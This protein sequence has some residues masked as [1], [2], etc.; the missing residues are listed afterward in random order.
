MYLSNRYYIDFGFY[1]YDTAKMI[2]SYI[3]EDKE[4][5]ST[6]KIGVIGV[7]ISNFD[8][9]KQLKEIGRL[10]EPAEY[11]SEFVEG[12]LRI[13][14]KDLNCV[15]CGHCVD[16]CTKNNLYYST[17][18]TRYFKG[19]VKKIKIHNV[20]CKVC[21]SFILKVKIKSLEIIQDFYFFTLIFIFIITIN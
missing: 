14:V 15:G 3:E 6:K 20:N 9:P 8:F 7:G 19:L 18:A 2:K 5:F 17:R 21:Y 12:E 11:I 10:L 1:G 4:K 13:A 16:I